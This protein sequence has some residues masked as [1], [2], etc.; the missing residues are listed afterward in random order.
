MAIR[1]RVLTVTD[2]HR[3]AAHYA[4]L[5]E[6][7]NR[8]RPHVVAFVGDFLHGWNDNAGRLSPE[9]CAV[10]IGRLPCRD[11]V[12]VRGNHEDHAWFPFAAA[13]QRTRRRLHALHGEGHAYEAFT[14]VGFPCFLGLE[15]PFLAGRPPL[16]TDTGEW[17]P[18]VLR[19]WGPA[20]RTLWL[21]HEPPAG[22]PLSEPETPVQGNVEWNQAI[23]EHQPLLTVSGHD[24]HSPVKNRCWAVKLGSTW[25]LNLGQS[26]GGPLHHALIEAEFQWSRA[27][28]PRFIS[29]TA[30]PWNEVLEIDPAVSPR[31]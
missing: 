30:Y 7:V 22:T 19:T 6:A 18:N 5:A 8:H 15:E 14:M 10:A 21:M 28:L 13:W 25:A 16:P 20:A 12:F 31:G 9:E 3:H 17:L 4:E 23:E 11:V 29:V 2:I 27:S 24:H 26:T 1:L